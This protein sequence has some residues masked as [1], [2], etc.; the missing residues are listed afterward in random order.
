MLTI[1][2]LA[3]IAGRPANDNMRSVI[4]GLK[5][6]GA[7]VGLFRPH[8]LAQYLPQLA[9]E[10]GA[11][12]Y[13]REIW[14]P[15][16]AQRGYEGRAD[17]GNT[18][19]GDGKKF[20]GHTPMMITGR[21]NTAEFLAWCRAEIDASAPDFLED[22]S[23]MNADPW[24]GLGPIWY[25][26]TRDLERYAETGNIEMITKRIN[27]GLNGYADRLAWY[28]RAALAL[29][30]FE[31][32]DVR[33]FQHAVGIA[34]DGDAGPQTRGALHAALAEL[35]RLQTLGTPDVPAAEVAALLEEA[36]ALINAGQL[37]IN[38]G[39]DL[40]AELAGRG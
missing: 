30:G 8:H 18:E 22:P 7:V 35:D 12:Q 1:D 16:A 37:S 3:A 33:G 15:T 20:M 5:A 32:E 21:A 9:H 27:G 31:P 11:F 6:G 29:L 28:A 2:K 36:T 25:W 24:E 40:L 10:S 14:G 34:V 17:L 26:A 38:Q 19:P 4:A 23:L 13:D 39:R